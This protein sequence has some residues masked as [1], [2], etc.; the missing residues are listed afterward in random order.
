MGWLA[1][2]LF[3]GYFT[4]LMC[5]IGINGLPLSGALTDKVNYAGV[6]TSL[7]LLGNY[8]MTQVY[9]HSEDARRGDLTLSRRMGIRGTFKLA[10]A[11]FLMVFVC[12]AWYFMVFFTMKYSALFGIA[13]FPVIVYFTHWLLLVR[14]D[15]GAADY[16]HAMRMNTVSATCL[17]VFFLFFFIDSHRL[18]NPA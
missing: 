9:Q 4:F 11:V 2:G 16:D 8:P 5:Y 17:N 18:I 10:G 1:A 12:F 15:A 7:M 6:L 14:Q 3:Q 13:V